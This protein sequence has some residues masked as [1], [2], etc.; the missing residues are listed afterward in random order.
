MAKRRLTPEQVIKKLREAEVAII[1]KATTWC[2]HTY[3]RLNPC[4]VGFFASASEILPL[5]SGGIYGPPYAQA[6]GAFTNDPGYCSSAKYRWD[7]AL[8]SSAK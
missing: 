8:I 6:W 3:G 4:P 5:A 7:A 1:E 2:P